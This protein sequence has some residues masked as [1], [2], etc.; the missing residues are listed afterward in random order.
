MSSAE[1]QHWRIYYSRKAQ[2]IDLATQAGGG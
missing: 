1:W 2:R